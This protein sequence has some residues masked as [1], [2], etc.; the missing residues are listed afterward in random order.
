MSQ[1]GTRSVY[2]WIG[3]LDIERS[4]IRVAVGAIGNGVN[5]RLPERLPAQDYE[6]VAPR[7]GVHA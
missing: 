4:G 7:R 1:G 6:H 3:R 2:A 5:S